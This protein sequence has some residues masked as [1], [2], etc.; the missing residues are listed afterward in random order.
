MRRISFL[1]F[2]F[3]FVLRHFYVDKLFRSS[4]NDIDRNTVGKKMNVSR[5]MISSRLLWKLSLV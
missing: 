4:I 5:L 2:L 1:A 3:P